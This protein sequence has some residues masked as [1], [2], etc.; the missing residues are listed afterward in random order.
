MNSCVIKAPSGTFS[1]AVI[2]GMGIL[3]QLKFQT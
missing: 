3:E 1:T 2:D